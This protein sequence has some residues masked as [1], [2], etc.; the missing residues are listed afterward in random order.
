MGSPKGLPIVSQPFQVVHVDHGPFAVV[1]LDQR[2]AAQVAPEPLGAR[3]E[4]HTSATN[5]HLA[6]LDRLD[7]LARSGEGGKLRDG[8]GGEGG[9]HEPHFFYHRMYYQ[10]EIRALKYIRLIIC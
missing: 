1:E 7:P 3:G 9:V 5:G 4:H 8:D 10:N 2:P 6:P